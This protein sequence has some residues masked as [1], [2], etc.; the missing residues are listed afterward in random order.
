MSDASHENDAARVPPRPGRASGGR[1]LAE[2]VT[3]AASGLLVLAVAGFLAYQAL[4][5]DGPY[6][7]AEL[8][9]LPERV[10]HRDG[11]FIL[12]VEVRN[13]GDRTLRDFRGEVV[14]RAPDGSADR[15]EFRIDY[16][17]ERATATVYV[18]SREDPAP[19]HIDARPL[20]YRLE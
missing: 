11:Q 10:E 2:W 8:R 18:Y 7:V 12:P 13:G 15:H 5:E 6:I 3:L 1:K 17:G 16:L 19:L 9:P 20:D 4:R 14:L